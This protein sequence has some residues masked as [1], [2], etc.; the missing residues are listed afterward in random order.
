MRRM[1]AGIRGI[2]M[3]D[4]AI[5]AGAVLLWIGLDKIIDWAPYVA[6]GSLLLAY[7]AT[8]MLLALRRRR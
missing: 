5:L 1:L 2:D 3:T 6:V 4:L 8:P 7:G